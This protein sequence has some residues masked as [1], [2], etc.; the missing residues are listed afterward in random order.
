M[1]TRTFEVFC[2]QSE[3]IVKQTLDWPVI[4]DAITAI[5]RRRN[6]MSC[7]S[8]IVDAKDARALTTQRAKHKR[9]EM[10]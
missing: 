6:A 10:V 4:R 2:C 1:V 7:L 5:S 8:Y 3:Q 9:H